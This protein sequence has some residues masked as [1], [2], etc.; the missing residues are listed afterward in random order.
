MASTPTIRHFLAL[1]KSIGYLASTPGVDSVPSAGRNHPAD[2]HASATSKLLAPCPGVG[3][4]FSAHREWNCLLTRPLHLPLLSR[5]WDLVPTKF[6]QAP[7]RV[8]LCWFVR[9]T[10]PMVHLLFLIPGFHLLLVTLTFAQTGI[11]T[12]NR[13]DLRK[14]TLCGRRTSY[15]LQKMRK[16]SIHYGRGRKSYQP[17]IP[18]AFF[19]FILGVEH[20]P[21]SGV[22]YS[23][24]DLRLRVRR[25]PEPV[26]QLDNAH[27]AWT[28]SMLYILCA[29]TSASTH[30]PGAR[31]T[32]GRG[33]IPAEPHPCAFVFL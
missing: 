20:G 14:V 10:Q 18:H 19:C 4:A 7:T 15:L 3:S 23:T 5:I 32:M 21:S 2:R 31:N 24:T 12:N 16:G 9:S 25:N 8:C 13:K 11:P 33:V 1:H 17:I 29:Q 26:S 27:S 6:E 28:S 22:S 30:L